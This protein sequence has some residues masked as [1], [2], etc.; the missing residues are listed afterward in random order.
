GAIQLAPVAIAAARRLG[1]RLFNHGP[2]RKL[3]YENVPSVVFSHPPIGTVGLNEDEAR[4]LH[5]DAVKVYQTRFTPMIYAPTDHQSHTAMKLVCVG[6]QER[7]VG[8]HI[9]GHGVDEML[10]GFAVALKMGAT[11]RDF[12]DTVAIHPTS[13]EELVTMR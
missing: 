5:G 4:K 6:A 12:D 13:S 8:V 3:N 2:E 10:Q 1:D 9:I 7:V 11:K